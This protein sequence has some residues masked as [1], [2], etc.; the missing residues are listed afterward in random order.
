MSGEVSASQLQAGQGAAGNA[1]GV[2]EPQAQ[3]QG[4][5]QQQQQ[6]QPPPPVPPPPLRLSM[7]SGRPPLP[8]SVPA[9]AT[10]SRASSPR[11]GLSAQP[12]LQTLNMNRQAQYRAAA[13]I[14]KPDT[15][16]RK[17]LSTGDV[18]ALRM[19]GGALLAVTELGGDPSDTSVV[20][21]AFQPREGTEPTDKLTHLEVIRQGKWLGL[22]SAAAGDR[23]LQA[24][25]RSTPSRLVFFSQNVGTWEQWELGSAGPD[26]DA[27]SWA[28]QPATLR[29]R[30][31][32][33]FELAVELVRVGTAALPPNASVAPRSLLAGAAGEQGLGG[34]AAAA[35]SADEDPS[36]ERRELQRMSGVLVHEWL[37]FVDQ[38]K[39]ARLAIEARVAQLAEDA[40]G[41]RDWAVMQVDSVRQELGAEVEQL[42]E[43]VRRKS[44]ELARAESRLSARE[45]WGVAIIQARGEAALKRQA[46]MWWRWFAA[47]KNYCRHVEA[48][49]AQRGNLRL[50]VRVLAAWTEWQERQA[51]VQAALRAAVRRMSFLKLYHAFTAWRD[52]VAFRRQQEEDAA[53]LLDAVCQHMQRWRLRRLL[54][55]WQQHSASC[56]QGRAALERMAVQ[57]DRRAASQALGAWRAH[58]AR[59]GER[60][61]S[62]AALVA[63]RQ[64]QR[65]QQ[66]VF[67][68]WQ[69]QTD[70][71]CGARLQEQH[72][73]QVLARLRL[74]QVFLAWQG[75]HRERAD[76]R[77]R[78]ESTL[79]YMR[80]RGYALRLDAAF[81]AWL[82][83]VAEQREQ[84][85]IFFSAVQHLAVRKM[86]VAFQAWRYLVAWRQHARA[87]VQQS[88]VRLSRRSLATAWQAW[89]E[90]VAE[91]RVERH[92]VAVCQRRQAL[93]LQRS[94]LAGWRQLAAAKAAEQQVVALCQRRANRNR[95]ALALAAL[96][97]NVA[98]ASAKREQHCLAAEWA[99]RQL[100]ARA[101]AALAE[102]VARRQQFE[103]QLGAV[104]QAVQRGVVR[105]AFRGW[106]AVG[107]REQ[108]LRQRLEVGLARIAQMRAAWAL[109]V[110]RQHTAGSVAEQQLVAAARRRLARIRLAAAFA[111]W[112]QHT[113]D[114]AE[115]RQAAEQLGQARDA[116]LLQDCL[117]GWA[118]AVAQR[119]QQQAALMHMVQ[120]R[121]AW[122]S[123]NVLHYWRAY[124]QH[125]QLW[126]AQLQRAVRKLSAVRQRG[127]FAAWQQTVAHRQA[128]DA[129]L[130]LAERRLAARHV[131]TTLA[132]ALRGWRTHTATLAA[133]RAAVDAKAAAQGAVVR[134]HV[135]AAW[136][137]HTEAE[138]VRRDH[139]LRVC[140]ARRCSL[141]QSKALVAWELYA[142][143]QAHNREAVELMVHRMAR[144][145]MHAALLSWQ[146][147]AQERRVR[148]IAMARF[149]QRWDAHRKAAALAH[150]RRLLAERRE[151]QEN[152][153]RCLMRKRVA[154]R[155]FRQWYWESFDEDMQE[156]LRT[157]FEI[158]EDAA[159]DPL[160]SRM[161]SPYGSLLSSPIRQQLYGMPRH[162]QLQL[163]AGVAEALARPGAQQP[164][165]L[166]ASADTRQDSGGGSLGGSLGLPGL[167]Q[168]EPLTARLAAAVAA[169]QGGGSE[170]Q[171][172]ATFTLHNNA[173]LEP[174]P[175]VSESPYAVRSPAPTVAAEAAAVA[176][177]AP[178]SSG[179]A[180]STASTAIPTSP[181]TPASAF[182]AGSSPL[183]GVSRL[184]TPLDF[185][186]GMQQ[187]QQQRPGL[188]PGALAAAATPGAASGWGSSPLAAALLDAPTPG[189]Y[190]LASAQRAAGLPELPASALRS[191]AALSYAGTPQPGL[192]QL[193]LSPLAAQRLAEAATPGAG[194]HGQYEIRRFSD[195]TEYAAPSRV[196]D[197][198]YSTPLAAQK[199]PP[200]G[201]AEL[202]GDYSIRRMSA[203]ED[204]GRKLAAEPT[205]LPDGSG[206]SPGLIAAF[207]GSASRG[208]AAGAADGNEGSLSAAKTPLLHVNPLAM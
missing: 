84:R 183:T 107:Q 7:L 169:G 46:F 77:R 97:D 66:A 23:F 205:P 106:Q 85:A 126:R 95:M 138:A 41:L 50:Q 145:V 136:C 1:D 91:A 204:E 161:G 58:V 134:R 105:E 21:F 133:A 104:A 198:E 175:E 179:K 48:K 74:R 60:L 15:Q 110:W 73:A 12:S 206:S 13:R 178:L 42:L 38:E 75:W 76:R 142:Q 193:G 100:Q 192:G 49:L 101:F 129:R 160:P 130:A 172:A 79:A 18:I 63:T 27:A 31:L 65:A 185:P 200:P 149:I 120:R 94:V 2:S 40:A 165:F 181:L 22:R 153:K 88:V 37:H 137:S 152:L 135:L 115:A 164:A 80:Q 195:G 128:E 26:P 4:V 188:S 194:L 71:R 144:R 180:S 203:A 163:S 56:A 69:Q 122:L 187:L 61:A 151:A 125:K 35:G 150:W 191:P 162:Q 54:R 124:M 148:R 116:A 143:R 10:S 154:F 109:D 14:F 28:S 131:A 139:I 174:V 167:P 34:G 112:Q 108:D 33:Q 103:Q 196:A 201:L 140:V 39:A 155:L 170:Q 24:R 121:A 8:R 78:W 68:A 9:S 96:H 16:P 98:E 72:A 30:R 118:D 190:S 202:Q 208:A 157:M 117:Q 176:G 19:Q 5:Q 81:A 114:V 158:T 184:P 93:A 189:A 55:A 171:F 92:R 20:H 111:S 113:A 53:A 36:L 207:L 3:Q 47:R 173:M 64:R 29:H 90:A 199:T 127:A 132:V 43:A 52:M 45:R 119:A 182:A 51:A 177:A 147:A 57:A 44:A 89:R 186:S 82:E 99:V 86:S 87:V 168:R 11:S 166:R 141:L 25:K 146:Q 32:P 102:A 67:D 6:Q 62:L 59:R 159:L 83:H 123:L 70:D 197:A 156:T 17:G